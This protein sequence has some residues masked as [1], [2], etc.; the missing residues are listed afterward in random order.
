M[1]KL[2]SCI[3]DSWKYVDDLLGLEI[4]APENGNWSKTSKM[5]ITSDIAH[6]CGA[7]ISPFE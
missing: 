2:K 1:D 4:I 6:D 5:P 3:I 7:I